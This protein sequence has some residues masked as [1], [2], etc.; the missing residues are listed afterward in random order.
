MIW[1]YAGLG[2]AG[3]VVVGFL[4]VRVLVAARGLGAEIERTKA[5]MRTI[6]PPEG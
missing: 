3:L 6:R 1:L 2:A 4:T 5:R